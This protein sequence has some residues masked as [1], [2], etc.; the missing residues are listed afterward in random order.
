MWKTSW[1]L[2]HWDTHDDPITSKITY[3]NFKEAIL[4]KKW[5][6]F[7]LLGKK[8]DYLP[9]KDFLKYECA[10]YLKQPLTPP[11]R[12]I[13]AT[14]YTLNYRL[15]IK[16]G[17]WSTI[18]ISRDTRLC[19]FC[20]YSTVENEAHFLLDCPLCK[21]IRAKFPSLFENVVLGSLKVFFSVGPPLITYEPW[22][23][24]GSYRMCTLICSI[25]WQIG[26]KYVVL[27]VW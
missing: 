13:I 11:Q 27:Q 20:S 19:H 25:S 14:Y 24:C 4:A 16:T 2:S 23:T 26:P 22:N 5:N 8:L 12:K 3:D 7:H 6:S 15:A 10:L 9:L 21:P 17:R 18:P 1:G